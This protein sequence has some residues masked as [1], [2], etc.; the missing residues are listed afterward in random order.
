[1]TNDQLN[2]IR[3]TKSPVSKG[4]LNGTSI[5]SHVLWT[6]VYLHTHTLI[7]WKELIKHGNVSISYQI[8]HNVYCTSI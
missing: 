7:T 6:D 2:G 1:M 5:S 4:L 8:H 3:H